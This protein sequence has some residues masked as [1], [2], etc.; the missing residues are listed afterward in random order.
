MQSI[1]IIHNIR[2]YGIDLIMKEVYL[3]FKFVETKKMK[4]VVV[5]IQKIEKTMDME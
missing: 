4:R 3:D 2:N 5:N 1:L